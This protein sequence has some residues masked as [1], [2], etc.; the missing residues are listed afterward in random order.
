MLRKSENTVS[1]KAGMLAIGVH[2]GLFV[3]LLLSVNWQTTH[4]VSIAEVE[5]WDTIPAVSKPAPIPEPVIA[6]KPEPKPANVIEK[7]VEPQLEPKADI[8]IK[9]EVKP[10]PPEKKPLEKKPIEKE[11]PDALAA[12]KKQMMQE[13]QQK[14]KDVQADKRKEELS[15]LQQEL[16][17]ESKNQN[18]QKSSASAGEIDKYKAQIQRKIQQK[19]NKSFCGYGKPELT[20]EITLSPDG[21]LQGN[22]KLI[23]SSNISACDDAVDRAILTSQPLPLP[24]DVSLRSQFRNLTLKFRPNDE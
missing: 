2:V 14:E 6:P 17:G 20:F 12:L 1:L 18:A 23:K 8:L 16:L 11:K 22:P 9:K 15:K 5:L 10:K 7:P 19:M 24:E 4:T 21:M 3:A 13:V